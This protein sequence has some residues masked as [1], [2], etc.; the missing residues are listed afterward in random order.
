[1]E[2]MWTTV[3]RDVAQYWQTYQS[4]TVGCVLV[5]LN[6]YG[7]F[8]MPP[9]SRSST[10]WGRYHTLASSYTLAAL[11]VWIVLANMPDL[12]PLLA[13]QAGLTGDVADLAA[14][15]YAALL[16]TVLVDV[17]PFSKGDK[18]IRDFLQD[19]A[20]IPIEAKRLSAA[21]R[22]HTWLPGPV[23]QDDVRRM[24]KDTGF[25]SGEI[26][27]TADRTPAAV[28]TKVT[29]LHQHVG[30][31][32]YERR[33]SGFYAQHRRE[34]QH[35]ADAYKALEDSARRF[36]R[37]TRLLDELPHGPAAEVR[38]ELTRHFVG[39][40][41]NVEKTICDLVS[42]ALLACALTG[43]AR[44]AELDSMGF[45]VSVAPSRLFDRML[46]LYLTLAGLYAVTFALARRPRPAVAAAIIATIYMGA[47]T[48]ALFPKRWPWALRNAAG[49]S[50]RA[51]TISAAIAV[52]FSLAASFG[53]GVLLTFS[54]RTAA[55]LLVGRFWPWSILA[56][57]M[58][59]GVAWT[60]DNSDR[61]RL[62]WAE[63]AIQA[64]IG[65]ASAAAVWL[66]LRELCHG[67]GPDCLPHPVRAIATNVVSGAVIGWFVPTWYRM[68]QV[69]TTDYRGW[70]VTVRTRPGEERRT[71]TAMELT[72][73]PGSGA[74]STVVAPEQEYEHGEEAIAASIVHAR[75]WIDRALPPGAVSAPAK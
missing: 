9:T 51:Y 22:A 13:E 47:I 8:N 16:I 67:A 31:W 59:F 54:T 39:S 68:P 10:T 65:A 66:L 21:L 15:L 43:K 42:R 4:W 2:S 73:P 5:A 71:A 28:W 29:A 74:A 45:V 26:S 70:K 75:R 37:V 50:I 1:M 52:A 72:P 38:T 69:L 57:A 30:R 25:G 27:F 20:R 19:L 64:G 3:S 49:R 60:A 46:G 12:F 55:D 33:F 35:A 14:P 7:R 18:R 34:F 11:V 36:F 62:R 17:K 41:E 40:A 61:P 48:A 24:L 44:R 56:A 58:A 63:S 32:E 6:S 23:L 53:L